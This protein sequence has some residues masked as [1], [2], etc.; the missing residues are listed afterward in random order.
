M[1]IAFFLFVFLFR[2]MKPG[3]KGIEAW[4]RAVILWIAAA[5]WSLEF[6][7]LFTMVTGSS[8]R[9]FWGCLALLLV[10]IILFL[11][12]RRRM[13]LSLLAELKRAFQNIWHHKLFASISLF[14]I[15]LSILT[16]PYN[17]DSMTYHLSRIANWAQNQSVAHYATHNIRELASP[18][19]AE[20]INLHVYILSGKKDYFFNLLQCFSALISAWIIYE[21]AI[22]IGCRKGYAML[23]S[24]LFLTMP[25]VFGEALSTQ[26]DL[27]AGIW[28]LIFAYYYLDLVHSDRRLGWN[29]ETWEYCVILASCVAFGY[30]AKPSVLIGMFLLLVFL[31]GICI[32]R[33]DAPVVMGKLVLLAIPV[34]GLLVLPEMLRNVATFSSITHSI[35][36]QRQLVGTGN[37]LYVLVNGLKNFVFNFPN[38][39]LPQ[40]SHWPAAMVYRIAALL[41]VN[42]DDPSISEDGRAFYLHAPQTYEPDTAVNPVFLCLFIVCLLWIIFRFRKQKKTMGGVWLL[43]S[44]FLFLAFCCLVRWEPFVSRYMISYMALLCPALAYEMQDFE[45]TFSSRGFAAWP[46]GIAA[47]MCCVELISLTAYHTGIMAEEKEDRFHGYFHNRREIYE[48]YEEVCDLV[49]EN[50]MGKIGLIISG[51]SYEYPIWQRLEG[52]VGG[53]WHVAVENESAGYERTDI[54]PDGVITTSDLGQELSVGGET[55][56]CLPQCSDNG[57]LYLYTRKIT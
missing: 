12:K 10:G 14:L 49:I 33:K 27:F 5:F 31:L 18:M 45:A 28:L 22:K 19:L 7:S 17:W 1:I 55:Y 54:H 39:Y 23:A 47:F 43:L 11:R 30:L 24:F 44:A 56:I 8:L 38:I 2:M 40:S 20:F 46:A 13:R 52:Y 35:A 15:V 32:R 36:G 37:P 4:M 25:S 9:I 34:M 50:E 26:V 53:I 57:Y 21:I 16:V 48:D 6:L 42:I 51:D 3:E 41:K 29:K